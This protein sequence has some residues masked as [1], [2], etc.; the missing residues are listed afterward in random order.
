M[1]LGVLGPSQQD[2]NKS[3]SVLDLSAGSVPIVRLEPR[4]GG[5]AGQVLDRIKLVV[6]PVQLH[7]SASNRGDLVGGKA[8]LTLPLQG[9]HSLMF[10]MHQSK[11]RKSLIK[12]TEIQDCVF[13]KCT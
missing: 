4:K 11:C 12:Q 1:K 13:L 7:H 5:R 3:H 8:R 9:L 10:L 2:D 6:Q